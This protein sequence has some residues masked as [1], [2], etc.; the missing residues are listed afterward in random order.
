MRALIIGYGSIGK[1]HAEVLNSIEEIDS[2][3][4]VTKQKVDNNKSYAT[5]ESVQN[6][7]SYDYYIISSETYKHFDQLKF[8]DKAVSDKKI[9]VEKPLFNKRI[10]Y[11][12][13]NSVF[14]GY[15]LRFHPVVEELKSLVQNKQVLNANIYVGSYLPD[16]RPDRDYSEVYSASKEM[17]GGVLLDLSHEFDYLQWLFGN[18]KNVYGISEKI[19]SLKIDT[20]DFASGIVKTENNIIVSFTMEFLAKKPIRQIIINTSEE[21]IIGDLINNKINIFSIHSYEK[22]MSF[23]GYNRNY[24]YM[25]MHKALLNGN[26]NK[27]AS[28]SDGNS[29]LEIIQNIQ[30]A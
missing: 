29:V 17:G 2:I 21:T 24:S 18:Y 3:E 13:K 16:W 30:S 8:I 9:L 22:E 7:C 14:V 5:L 6:I 15:N 25:Q 12:P 20:E 19:S 10:E 23:K 28:F 4:L 1:R 27:I 26:L 11:S